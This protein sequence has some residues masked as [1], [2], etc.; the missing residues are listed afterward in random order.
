MTATS[1]IEFSGTCNENVFIAQ[2]GVTIQ[3]LSGNSSQAI[4]NGE[5]GISGASRVRIENITIDG[6]QS[7]FIVDGAT[8]RIQ[9]SVIENTQ[10]GVA[11][12]RDSHAR[13]ENNIIGPA[14]VDDGNVSCT[15]LCVL[16]DASVRMIGNTVTG[17][18]NDPA[19]AVLVIGR[20]SSALM[21]GGNH[22]SNNGTQPAVTVFDDASLRIDNISGLVRDHITGDIELFAISQVDVREMLLTGNLT[23]TEHSMMRLGSTVGFGGDPSN[24]EVNGD[25][26]LSFDSALIVL[27]PEIMLNGAITCL[28]NE[29]SLNTNDFAGDHTIDCTDFNGISLGTPSP[30]TPFPFPFP[31][32]PAPP[33]PNPNPNPF[34]FPFP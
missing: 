14:L 24:I 34:P 10:N 21:R 33:N 23:V 30:P 4:I 18:A 8:V 27:N 31:S 20:D 9:N 13:L 26:T 15:P 25:I 12:V 19:S 2:D 17:A 6:G 5:L 28:D 3:S 29:S 1:F 32:P 11:I 22:I 16:D 7:V